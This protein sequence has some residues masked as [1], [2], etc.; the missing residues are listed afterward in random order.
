MNL[1]KNMVLQLVVSALVFFLAFR[2]LSFL[3]GGLVLL[4]LLGVGIWVLLRNPAAKA[5]VGGWVRGLGR[6]GSSSSTSG[7]QA[8]RRP[9]APEDRPLSHEE[10]EAF[11]DI[12]RGQNPEGG[13]SQR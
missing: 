13:S 5:R 12:V 10:R 11:N 2:L 9:R 8:P 6:S 7:A 4:L 3:G 1:N